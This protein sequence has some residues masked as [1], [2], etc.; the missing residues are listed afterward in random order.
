[1]CAKSLQSCQILCDPVDSSPP[2]SSVYGI[3]RQEY[4]SGLPFISPGDLPNSTIES[5]SPALQVGSLLTELLG[6]WEGPLLLSNHHLGKSVCYPIP[7]NVSKIQFTESLIS[8][9]FRVILNMAYSS[10]FCTYHKII[11]S[12]ILF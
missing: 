4:W 12:R 9:L 8:L 11:G 2:G 5:R 7:E 6:K 10:T 1:M 3:S